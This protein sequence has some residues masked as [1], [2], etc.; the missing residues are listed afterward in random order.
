MKRR[1]I[2]LAKPIVERFPKLAT[3]YRYIRDSR[4][5]NEIPQQTPFGFKFVGN[6]QMLNGAFE[7][8]E[9]RIMQRFISQVDVLINVGANIG[10]YCC[11]AL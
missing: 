5:I 4:F 9:T 7:P 1:L 8:E 10:Y 11:L 2:Q 3:L 6:H